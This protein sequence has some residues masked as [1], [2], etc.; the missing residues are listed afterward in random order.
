MMR[1]KQQK[2]ISD[3]YAL[4]LTMAQSVR[5][6]AMEEP[7]VLIERKH[8][9]DTY[10]AVYHNGYTID[11][12]KDDINPIRIFIW[13]M[14]DKEQHRLAVKTNVLWELDTTDRP[15]LKTQREAMDWALEFIDEVHNH[16]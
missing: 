13:E 16:A 5:I 3:E 14:Q 12:R 6:Q 1:E 11:I 10:Q 8:Q 9:G 2:K 4:I 7:G 15:Q